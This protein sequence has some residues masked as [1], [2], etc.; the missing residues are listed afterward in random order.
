MSS[1]KK[2]FVLEWF[3]CPKDR[4]KEAIKN[5]CSEVKGLREATTQEIIA[6]A[7]ATG[8]VVRKND[9]EKLVWLNSFEKCNKKWKQ[10]IQE[11]IKKLGTYYHQT[12]IIKMLKELISE[13]D[14]H[15]C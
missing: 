15:G 3:V 10:K 5:D 8:E 7:L 14:Q 9:I 11:L 1:E 13:G 4:G 2:L 12:E 6:A